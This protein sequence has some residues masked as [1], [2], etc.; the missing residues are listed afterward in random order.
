M[1]TTKKKKK[2]GTIADRTCY[3][4]PSSSS[5]KWRSG[6]ISSVRSSGH[7][8]PSSSEIVPRPISHTSSCREMRTSSKTPPT[9]CGR[10][11]PLW[12]LRYFW[13][14]RLEAHQR[15]QCTND[16]LVTR[17]RVHHTGGVCCHTDQQVINGLTKTP[18]QCT[19]IVRHGEW[20][21]VVQFNKVVAMRDH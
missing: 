19:F 16:G 6:P 3:M 9:S 10:N 5:A 21:P 4:L 13:G 17:G 7:P 2:I 20:N 14:S 15:A 11:A 12:W 1:T 8:S 18:N